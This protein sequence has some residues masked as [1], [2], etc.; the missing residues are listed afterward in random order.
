MPLPPDLALN[1]LTGQISGVPT[2]PGTYSFTLRVR[3]AQG[4]LRDIAQ[5]ITVQAYTPPSLSGTLPQFSTR[6]TAYSGSFAVANGTPPFV[7]SISSGTLPTGITI[8]SSTGAISGTPTDT[9]Y[10]DRAITVRAVDAIGSAA[11]RTATIRYADTFALSGSLPAGVQG[12]PYSAGFTRSGGHTPITFSLQAGTLP[13]GLSLSSTTGVIS[14]TPAAVTSAAITVRATDASGATVDR[15]QTLTINSSYVP[16]SFSGAIANGSQNV[17]TRSAFSITPDYSGVT[18]SG[19]SGGVTYSW[20][21]ISGSADVSAGSPTAFGTSFVGTVAPSASVSATFRCTATDGISSATIDVTITATNTYQTLS[22]SYALGRATRTVA[23]SRAPTVSGGASPLSYAVV[24]GTLPAG[25]SLS[26]STGDITGT[27]TDTTYTD[28]A[29]TV[30]VTDAL[31]ATVDPASTMTYRNAPAVTYTL[32]AAMRT[33]S[34]ATSPSIAAG[35]HGGNVFA[36]TSGTLPASLSLSASTGDITGT[37]TDT[38]YGTR[39][40][41]FQLTDSAGNVATQSGV[42]LAYADN[43]ALAGAFPAGTAGT[44]YSS[45]AVTASGGHGGNAW[46]IASGALPGGLSLNAGTGALTGTPSASGMFNFTVRVTDSRGFTADSAQSINV[47]AA[48]SVSVSPASVAGMIANNPPSNS[49]ASRTV[50]SSTV[51]AT[52]AN[53]TGPFTYSWARIAGSSAIS[54]GLPTAATTGFS[55]T[56][57]IDQQISATFRVTVTD[58]LSATATADTTVTLEYVSGF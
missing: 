16:L 34:Y 19:G 5:S 29:I 14:G 53:G 40:L 2:T 57:G 58:A 36:V 4:S 24:A 50:N 38:T 20:A 13:S 23:Y 17:L 21:R 52:P 51:T 30:R 46:S 35:G 6:G 1:P 49:P 27:P 18:L 54:A 37:P 8:N 15:S 26:A 22:A 43:L 31:G 45:S 47:V 44:A 42:S 9:T 28:R 39:T 55:G 7:W 48:L 10:T 32:P 3:D 41:A 11:Q 33:R 56:V 12:T 25:L